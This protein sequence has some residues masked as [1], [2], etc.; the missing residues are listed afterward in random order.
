MP[1]Q[2]QKISVISKVS[3]PKEKH[4]KHQIK[5]FLHT[6]IHHL[7]IINPA[8]NTSTNRILL[9]MATHSKAII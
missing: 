3:D 4:I 1:D 7:K 2:I 6:D 5:E 8:H 9:L